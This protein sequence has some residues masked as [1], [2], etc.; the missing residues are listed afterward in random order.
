MLFWY[1]ITSH[2]GEEIGCPCTSTD[3]LFYETLARQDKL[4]F[5]ETRPRIIYGAR[6]SRSWNK[7]NLPATLLLRQVPTQ[8]NPYLSVRQ[9]PGT[10]TFVS[11]SFLAVEYVSRSRNSYC[12][13]TCF[14]KFCLFYQFPDV[15]FNK[16]STLQTPKKL[17]T[18]L[19]T[20]TTVLPLLDVALITLTVITTWRFHTDCTDHVSD[21]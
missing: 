11:A 3:S 10:L 14:V 18:C 6:N 2:V 19:L 16:P 8:F 1:S 20:A 9:F 4:T 17:F 15:P 7:W 13:R 21:T 5:S 12:K